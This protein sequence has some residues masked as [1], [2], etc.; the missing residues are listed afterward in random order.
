MNFLAPFSVFNKR[1]SNLAKVANTGSLDSFISALFP[2]VWYDPSDF[3]TLFTDSAGATPVTALEQPVGLM[4]DKS[5]NNRHAYHTPGDTTTR[6]VV[7]RRINEFVGTETL[8]T[9]NVTTRATNYSLRF[10]GAGSITLSGT[11]TGTYSAGTHTITCTAGTLTATVSGSVTQAMLTPS[12]LAVLPYQ[13]VNTTTDYDTSSVFPTFL[14]CDGVNDSL[15]TNAIDFSATDKMFVGAAVRKLSDAGQSIFEF[16]ANVNS[17]N[18]AFAMFAGDASGRLW[19]AASRGTANTA[20]GD[21]TA[22][23]NTSA[24][25]LLADISAP[26]L[27]LRRNGATGSNGGFPA[28][29]TA[30]QGTG[31]YGNHKLY[32][33]MRGGTTLPF[34][35]WMFGLL[36]KGATLSASQIALAERWLASKT[37]TVVL[38]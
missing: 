32:L 26:L 15:Q 28:T 35:G 34:N 11:A 22:A 8:A 30:T 12:G 21:S 7:S 37:K 19:S 2:D 31:N 13:R 10:S 23:P 5:G 9:Q 29:S 16:S 27:T 1:A 20:V 6:P 14:R 36:I 17:N 3:S 25:V 33:F 38:A 18:G 24:I 4:K